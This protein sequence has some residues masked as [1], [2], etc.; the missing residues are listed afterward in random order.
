MHFA[1]SIA[2]HHIYTISLYTTYQLQSSRKNKPWIFERVDLAGLF[3]FTDLWK[4]ILA[5]LKKF[6][7]LVKLYFPQLKKFFFF[8]ELL[9]SLRFYDV[10]EWKKSKIKMYLE[11]YLTKTVWSN[12]LRE[13]ARLLLTVLENI[14]FITHTSICDLLLSWACLPTYLRERQHQSNQNINSP[15]DWCKF[16]KKHVIHQFNQNF[17]STTKVNFGSTNFVI[18]HVLERGEWILL[19]LDRMHQEIGLRPL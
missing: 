2:F 19:W 16:G 7:V 10:Y 8:F 12:D 18:S 3:I 6:C 1:K 11:K 4:F 5:T 17:M 13:K 15:R 14:F 9:E